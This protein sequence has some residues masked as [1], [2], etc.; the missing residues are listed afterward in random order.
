[1]KKILTA[2]IISALMTLPSFA[3]DNQKP[4]KYEIGNYN[5]SFDTLEDKNQSE[6]E[7][8]KDVSPQEKSQIE[9]AEEMSKVVLPETSK[10]EPIIDEKI[11]PVAESINT[12]KQVVKQIKQEEQAKNDLKEIIKEQPSAI[13]EKEEQKIIEQTECETQIPEEINNEEI[14]TPIPQ[15]SVT[16]K[17]ENLKSKTNIQVKTHTPMPTQ[18]VLDEEHSTVAG[19][20]TPVKRV[21]QPTKPPAKEPQRSK[22]VEEKIEEITLTEIKQ[23]NNS[24]N[25]NQSVNNSEKQT[26]KDKNTKQKTKEKKKLPF[27]FEL[28]KMQ[29]NGVD[30]RQL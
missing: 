5:F 25:E 13:Q 27:S 10:V 12:Q 1:M 26:D 2:T 30:S 28:Q 24:D 4:V 8:I 22:V 21:V 11:K 17:E 16:P 29:Y 6:Q 19:N 7:E 18:K 20:E 23:I 14:K 3:A 9:Q 15:S